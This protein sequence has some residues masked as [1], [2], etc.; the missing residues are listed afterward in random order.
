[1][2]VVWA[3]HHLALDTE[4]AV[5]LIRPERVAADP[6]LL[7]RF[8][9]EAKATAR[10]AHP[11]VV[12]VMDYGTVD[13]AVPY[14]VMELLQGF[15]VAELLER[16]GRLSVATAKSLLEQVAGALESAHAHGI[17]HRDI[18]PHNLFITEISHG[19]PLFVKVLDFGVAKTLGETQVPGSSHLTE[20]GTILGSPPYMS[21]EQIQGSRDVDLRSDLWS[22]GVIVY[23]CLT[24]TR[25][26]D[27]SS[28]VAVGAA[29]LH[30][31]YRPA[32]ELRP[33]LPKRVDHWFAK[34]LCTDVEG[35]FQSAR[36]MAAAFEPHEAPPDHAHDA[37]TSAA[38]STAAI[39]SRA[40]EATDD[41][42]SPAPRPPPPTTAEHSNGDATPL[43]SRPDTTRERSKR[44]RRLALITA[45]AACAAIAAGAG[46]RPA[47]SAGC[48]AGMVLIEGASFRMGSAPDAETPSDETPIH[49]ATVS[50]FCLDVTEVTVIAY[51]GCAE[52][53][54]AAKTV[55]FEGLT[56]NGR[57]FESQFCNGVDAPDH[58]INCI[59]WHQASAYCASR[60]KRL[61]TEQEWELAARGQDAR[62]YPWGPRA[63]SAELLNACGA[64]CSRML[65]E[66]RTAVGKGP[67]PAMYPTD[68]R[69]AATA[70]VG[71]HPAGAS[72]AG[73]QDLA[74]NVWEWTD[75]PY[76]PYQT[77]TCGD[78]RRVL[79]GG[80][81]DTTE[82]QDTR[83]ARR[84][85]T[86]PTARG[87]STG[88]RCA[89][90]P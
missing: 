43:R 78:S 56:P 41:H 44:R 16:G 61:P 21:P 89:Q 84:Y 65:T 12:K 75:T 54:P 73:I 55:E 83:S 22:L 80:G 42:A 64:E 27:G 48:P 34:A 63:P 58:P 5:K 31:K 45:A 82:S 68:D 81:W 10:I 60:G 26:F 11:H 85:P 76:C 69:A 72:Q 51:A 38:V 25:P 66:R 30:G 90:T 79:R 15:S 36:A 37:G 33:T 47:G 8:E 77:P 46:L 18:K 71:S 53:T 13:G 67:W 52:C 32:S 62:T 6:A 23:E 28:F 3:A 20:T 57:S 59:D 49:R 24:A 1:M 50:S 88:F 7:A 86:A 70:A 2:G 39:P 14:I 29:V 4:V 74:G 35:R 19:D 40:S 17:V 9:R 87:R